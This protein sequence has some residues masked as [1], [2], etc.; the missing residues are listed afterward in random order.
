MEQSTIQTILLIIG[1]A[2]LTV[3]LYRFIYFIYPYIRP[4]SIKKYLHSGSYAL[5]T[6][7]T[8]GIGKALAI[9]L[10]AKGFNIILHGRNLNKLTAVSNEIQAAHPS[11]DVVSLLQDGSKN[12]ILDISPIRH[13]PISVLVNN[14]GVGPIAELEQFSIEQIAE[15]VNLNALFP[16]HVTHSVLPQMPRPAL[17]LNV[18]SYVGIFPPPYLAVYAGTKAY[19]TAFSNSLSRE[20]P[21]IETIAL[22]TGSVHSAGNQKPVSF[23]RPASS[24]YARHILSIIGSGRKSIMPY[25]PHAVQVFI[26]S[27]LPAWVTERAIKQAIDKELIN[28]VKH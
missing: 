20:I 25:W 1:I 21:S 4:S 19:N 17:I 3:T 6:G 8:D 12:P 10:A 13:L 27:L 23:F 28:N 16:T 11:R 26:L 24:V 7:A 5:V 9:E 2:T 18:S 22:I 14:V 15:T